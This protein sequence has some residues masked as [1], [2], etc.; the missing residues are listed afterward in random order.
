MSRRLILRPGAIGDTIVCLPALQHL[1]TDATELWAPSVNL[2][3]LSHLGTT[4]PLVSTGIDALHL[5]PA[6]LD[7]LRQFDE[8]V[9]WYGSNREDFRAQVAHLPFRFFPA[10]PPSGMKMHAVDY[11]LDQV[12]APL[13]GMP[14]LPIAHRPHGFAVIHPFSGGKSKNWPLSRFQEV[15]QLLP[16]PVQWCAGPDESLDEAIRFNDLGDLAQWLATASLYIGNDSGISHLAAA[17]GVPVVAI[18]GPTNPAVWAPRG[19]HVR[20]AE[21]DWPPERVA[22]EAAAL[23]TASAGTRSR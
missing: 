7:R 6:T 10:L 5:A 16:L 17:C 3:L 9:S 8:I 22:A 14:R 18:F 11:Y 13:G 4:R 20:I 2:P 23:L 15:A 1:C 21:W 12:G 19:P